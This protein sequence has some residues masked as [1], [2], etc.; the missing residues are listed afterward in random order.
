MLTLP[1]ALKCTQN[2]DQSFPLLFFLSVLGLGHYSTSPRP[3]VRLT[4]VQWAADSLSRNGSSSHVSTSVP[5][6][7]PPALTLLLTPAR[8]P[9]LLP[10][11]PVMPCVRRSRVLQQELLRQRGPLSGRWVSRRVWSEDVLVRFW[12]GGGA[13]GVGGHGG[14]AG[15]G[16]CMSRVRSSTMKRWKQEVEEISLL[17]DSVRTIQ[18]KAFD[19][20]NSVNWSHNRE[21]FILL[22]LFWSSLF[23]SRF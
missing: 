16:G 13:G 14:W 6:H 2:P 7:L 22:N 17:C 10:P 21:S 12:E 8:L 18:M 19:L 15:W 5:P 4:S 3:P 11:P 1:H 23:I 20:I 9:R